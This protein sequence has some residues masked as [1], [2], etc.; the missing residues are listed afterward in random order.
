M[1]LKVRLPNGR[2]IKVNTEDPEYAK[3]QAVDYYKSGKRG[4]VDGTTKEL[5]TQFDKRF[6]YESGVD[7]TWLRTK[8]GAMETL[9]GKENVLTNAVGSK[10]FTRDSKGNLALTQMV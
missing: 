7:A 10:G 2:Y 8:L 9:G 1:S 4:F 6:D 5:G 3:Q